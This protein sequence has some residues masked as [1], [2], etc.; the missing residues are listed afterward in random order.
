[1]TNDEIAKTLS[2]KEAELSRAS[3]K[4]SDQKQ[5]IEDLELQRNQYLEQVNNLEIAVR[6]LK[7]FID[8]AEMKFYSIGGTAYGWD[9]IDI[10]GTQRISPSW[11]ESLR[12]LYVE[13]KDLTGSW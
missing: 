12:K 8:M 5:R 6:I 4:I 2:I 11:E 1:M 13:I 10:G 7:D 3:I 9:N